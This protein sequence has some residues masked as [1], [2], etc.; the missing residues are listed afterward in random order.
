LEN[1]S[2]V[3]PSPVRFRSETGNLASMQNSSSR[4]TLGSNDNRR[5]E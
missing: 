1:P 2:L 4:P 3:M 5:S